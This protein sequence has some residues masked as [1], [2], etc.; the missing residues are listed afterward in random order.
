MAVNNYN[1]WRVGRMKSNILIVDDDQIIRDSLKEILRV[2]G[3]E[4]DAAESADQAI[5][6]LAN[7]TFDLVLL[8]LQM[9]GMDGLEVLSEVTRLAP[10]TRVILLTAHGSLES[11][12]EALRFGAHDYILKASSPGA[13]L[14]SIA[15]GMA[16]RAEQQRKRQLLNQIDSSL[17]FLKDAER[18]TYSTTSEQ[19]SNSLP[20]GVDEIAP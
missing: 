11:A 1:T 4:V 6:K 18:S 8:D 5:I 16:K 14:S 7:K 3:Y 10:D 13:V 19:A 17:G 12:I 20:D 2:E 15:R 9:P